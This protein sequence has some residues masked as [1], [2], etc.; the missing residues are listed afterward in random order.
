MALWKVYC[1]EDV[2]PGLWHR[3]YRQQCVAIGWPGHKWHGKSR[4]RGLI[5]ARNAVE[6]MNVG[7][8]VIAALKGNRVGRMGQITAINVKDEEWN[9]LVPISR[10]LPKG[11]MGRRIHVRWELDCG[12]SHPDFDVALPETH[13]FTRGELLPTVAQI[14]SQTID[15]LRGAMNDDANWV[16]LL[17]FRYERALSDYI[18]AYPHHLED[19]MVPHP[20]SKVRE[21]VF[22]DSKRLDVLLIDRED[23]PVVVE[24]KQR[25][26]TVQNLKQLRHYM[27]R[28]KHETGRADVRGIRVH[29][30][31]RKLHPS[32]LAAA[33]NTPVVEIVQYRLQME[34]AGC[35]TA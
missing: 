18:A 7:D 20:D 35:V 26:P 3:L 25:A 6:E 32:V 23:R 21:K 22:S 4:D 14:R 12:P 17:S 8:H 11:Q 16:G 27:R 31:A 10:D 15:D 29:G 24:C 1:L 28:L 19:G 2:F 30:G 34:F 9:P 5:R 13:R 33:A